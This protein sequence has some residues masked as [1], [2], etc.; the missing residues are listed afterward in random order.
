[1]DSKLEDYYE[2]DDYVFVHGGLDVRLCN[3]KDQEGEA[4]R[5]ARHTGRDYYGKYH[6]MVIHGHTP[7]ADPQVDKNR[8]NVDTSWSFGKYPGILNLT[9]VALPNRRDDVFSPPRF[10]E[11]KKHFPHLEKYCK[12]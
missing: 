11:A 9:A 12:A 4:L 2:T 5:W 6:K 7:N 1:M 8:I 3:M 10:I